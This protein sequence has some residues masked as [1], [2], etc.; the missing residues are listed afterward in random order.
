MINML[1]HLEAYQASYHHV[2]I[3]LLL[4][5]DLIH[6]HTRISFHSSIGLNQEMQ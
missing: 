3:L 6:S 5:I 2:I 1:N 4:L